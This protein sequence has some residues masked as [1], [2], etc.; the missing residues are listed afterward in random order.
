M[1]MRPRFL[2][3]TSSL[4][5]ALL[6]PVAWA[7]DEATDAMNAAYAPYRAA[8]F[9]TNSKAQVESEQAIVSTRR[10]WQAV[11]DRYAGKPPLPYDRDADFA[12]T[13]AKVA[14]VYEQAEREIREQQLPQAHETLEHARDL[15]SALRQRNGVIAYSDH[16]NAYHAAMEQILTAGPKLLSG[17]QGAIQL[18]PAVGV[19]EYLASRLRSDAPTA[20]QRDAE[21]VSSVQAVEASV[22]VLRTAALSQDVA[23]LRQALGALKG[24]YSRMFLKFG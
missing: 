13:L 20:L 17:P 8:L 12:S 1:T 15:L 2:F 24:P 18:L 7:A 19:L 9:R 5:A 22:A 6:L 11:I 16:M 10:A 3:A 21:F 4:A 14:A 23:A